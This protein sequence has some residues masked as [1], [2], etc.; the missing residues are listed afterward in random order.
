MSL[1]KAGQKHGKKTGAEKF[2]YLGITLTDQNFMQV[3]IK[4]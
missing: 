1:K 4:S 3:E 2:K